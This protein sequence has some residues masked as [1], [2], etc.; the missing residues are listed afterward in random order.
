MAHITSENSLE[1]WYN[2]HQKGKQ[3]KPYWVIHKDRNEAANGKGKCWLR[4]SDEPNYSEKI[5]VNDLMEA[6]RELPH[7]TKVLI[8]LRSD[9]DKYTDTAETDYTHIDPSQ[10]YANVGSVGRGFTQEDINS[11]VEKA[12]AEL[13]KEQ[14]YEAK[15]KQLE[16]KIEDAKATNW[17]RILDH[18]T[19]KL[20]VPHLISGIQNLINPMKPETITAAITASA[21]SGTQETDE[22]IRM[23]NALIKFATADPNCLEVLEKMADI[24]ANKPANYNTYKPMLLAM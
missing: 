12:L 2:L 7:N 3:T 8:R 1:K 20:A 16:E 13:K 15:L 14:T 5:G 11:A 22:Q 19:V 4:S 10:Q 24:A 6:V 17:E 21:V 9:S 23:E 18:P